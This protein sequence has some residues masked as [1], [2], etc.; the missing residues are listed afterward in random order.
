MRKPL[1]VAAGL[2]R[3]RATQHSVRTTPT[4]NCSKKQRPPRRG[5][6]A[7]PGIPFPG[8]RA[9]TLPQPAGRSPPSRS[10]RRLLPVSVQRVRGR[11]WTK[12]RTCALF[13]R[14]VR[15]REASE[16]ASFRCAFKT[17]EAC[18]RVVT[19][20]VGGFGGRESCGKMADLPLDVARPERIRIVCSRLHYA[21]VINL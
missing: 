18:V 2:T 8:P 9:S 5:R 1:P 21:F 7:A 10:L 12:W 13:A 14:A 4:K 20:S 6:S 15:V 19:I 16:R 17:S 11:E 3:A